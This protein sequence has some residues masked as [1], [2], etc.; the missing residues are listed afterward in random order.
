M[1]CPRDAKGTWGKCSGPGL[2]DAMSLEK[3]VMGTGKGGHLK[4][5]SVSGCEHAALEASSGYGDPQES[6]LEVQGGDSWETS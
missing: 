6:E 2:M 4:R 5:A 3:A 1:D